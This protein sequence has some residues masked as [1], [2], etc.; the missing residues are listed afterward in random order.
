VYDES[1]RQTPLLSWDG[2]VRF[3]SEAD[4]SE[5]SIDVRFASKSGH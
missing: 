1:D 5:R 3:G 4:I 2:F